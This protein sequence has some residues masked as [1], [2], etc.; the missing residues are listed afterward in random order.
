MS[1]PWPLI[2]ED[3]HGNTNE[4]TLESG[5]LLLYE[6]SKVYHGRPKPFEGSWYT[7]LFL[8]YYPME[9]DG[10]TIL[11][12][13]HYRIPPTWYHAVPKKEEV[14]ELVV[15]DTSIKEPNCEYQ[16]CA[17]KDSVTYS[18]PA[19]FEYV[20]TPKGLKPLMNNDDADTNEL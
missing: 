4:V 19:K 12:D 14:D 3:L 20:F 9:W 7:S 18:G 15:V 11:Y 1:K 5:D 17:L 16:W 13:T 10:N 6:S 8:H 2:L